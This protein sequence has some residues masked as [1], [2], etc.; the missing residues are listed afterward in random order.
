MRENSMT[1]RGALE[2]LKEWAGVASFVAMVFVAGT[3]WATLQMR[4]AALE[5]R[6]A[7]IETAS[8]SAN[9]ALVKKCVEL[10]DRA[11]SSSFDASNANAAMLRLGCDRMK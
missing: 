4:V 7:K 2:W 8:T 5:A 9:A 11:A 10:S 1:K 6:V 3:T